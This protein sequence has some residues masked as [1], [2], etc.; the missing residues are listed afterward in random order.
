MD[1]NGQQKKKIK[2]KVIQT[3]RKELLEYLQSKLT[4]FVAHNFV[5]RW[6]DN[7]CHLAM[8]NLPDD[9]IL[10]HIDFTKNYTF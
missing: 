1:N 10:S 2:E 5:A 3:S 4:R 6:Q 8:E 9:A 7:Q